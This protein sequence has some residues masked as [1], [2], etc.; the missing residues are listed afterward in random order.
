MFQKSNF[1]LARECVETLARGV[2][3][4]PQIRHSTQSSNR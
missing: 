1:A 2:S 3:R 4:V